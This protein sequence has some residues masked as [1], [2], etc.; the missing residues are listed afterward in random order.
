MTSR[1]TMCDVRA[2][3]Q[4]ATAEGN[5]AKEQDKTAGEPY[6]TLPPRRREYPPDAADHQH[7]REGSQSKRRH[8]E[9]AWDR[10]ASAH[11]FGRKGIN[12]RTRQEAVEHPK[13]ERCRA[14]A[15]RQQAAQ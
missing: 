12:Q 2:E 15:G 13:S 5:K 3:G 8:G 14:A 11:R 1:P 4:D 7:R 9:K 6:A 10:L